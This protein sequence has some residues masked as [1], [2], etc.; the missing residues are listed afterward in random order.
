MAVVKVGFIVADHSRVTSS[1]SCEFFLR[2]VW[3]GTASPCRQRR[4]IAA[5]RRLEAAA[6]A[7]AVNWV[8]PLG[9]R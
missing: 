5:V 8:G 2:W 7:V 4:V 9:T 6:A 3:S 1:V